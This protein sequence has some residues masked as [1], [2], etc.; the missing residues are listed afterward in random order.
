MI[1]LLYCLR[2]RSQLT[3]REF[4]EHWL[5]HHA[6]FGRLTPQVRRLVQYHTLLED[7]IREALAQ[8]SAS[9]TVVEPYDGMA[10]VW[11]ESPQTLAESMR[12]RQC[13]GGPGRRE[14]LH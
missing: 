13:G 6:R 12:L 5:E 9:D 2:R 3:P 14:A 8:A 1:K 10:V 11:F 7:P 4:H